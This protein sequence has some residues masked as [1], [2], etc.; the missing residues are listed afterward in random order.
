MAYYNNLNIHLAGSGL[1]FPDHFHPRPYH[2]V[3][4]S[5]N[6]HY[7]TSHGHKPSSKH[8]DIGDSMVNNI[9]VSWG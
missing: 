3:N 2:I 7:G 9:H 1:C 5:N 8:H 6:T 4:I